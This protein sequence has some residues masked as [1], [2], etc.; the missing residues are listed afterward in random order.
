MEGN[1]GVTSNTQT[2][3]ILGFQKEVKEKKENNHYFKK[4]VAENP[5]HL[6]KETDIQTQEA[7]SSKHDGSK[8]THTKTYD[9]VVK[10]AKVKHK[11]RI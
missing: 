3:T 11:E 10:T 7:Q 1:S 4:T 8:E 6:R 5:P 9:T 2:F